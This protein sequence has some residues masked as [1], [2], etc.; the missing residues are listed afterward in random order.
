SACLVSLA[1][2]ETA[3]ARWV[4]TFDTSVRYYAWSNTIGGSG[5]QLYVPYAA[6]TVGRPND[7]WK[8]EFLI[9]S[10]YISSRQ[11]ANG[12]SAEAESLT[13]TTLSSTFT[14][15]GWNGVHP[16]VSMNINMPTAHKSNGSAPTA[17]P[18]SDL[19][20]TPI[21]GQGWNVGPSAGASIA[22]DRSLI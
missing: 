4:N 17:K 5:S 19:V 2:A 11:S 21:F 6:Q 7:D 13:D 20:K 18:D 15:L 1:Q 10:G 8:I 9:R 3:P 22:I 12:A 14:Y 16:F